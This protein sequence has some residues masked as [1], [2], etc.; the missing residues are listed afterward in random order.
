MTRRIA[1]A[2]TALV[3]AIVFMMALPG[4]ALFRQEEERALRL[5][6]ERDALVLADDASVGDASVWTPQLIE[7]AQSSGARL[8]VVNSQGQVVVDTEGKPAGSAFNR[9]EITSALAGQIVTGVRPSAT[10][11]QQLTYAAVPIRSGGAVVGALRISMPASTVDQSVR[12]L[13]IGLAL[14]LVGIWVLAIVTSW[15]LASWL[16]RPLRFLAEAARAVGA[17]PH[18]RVGRLRGP[19]E[20]AEVAEALDDTAEQ[21]SDALDRSRAVAEESSH[22][23]RTPLAVLRL[24]LEAISDETEG[25][26]HDEA[27]AALAEADRLNH[28]IGQIL[29]LARAGVEAAAVVVDVAE[30]VAAR[31]AV[32]RAGADAQGV[33]LAA[34]GPAHAPLWAS[35]LPGDVD[36]TADELLSNALLYATSSITVDVTSEDEWAV[37]TVRDD[38]PGFPPGE[39]DHV[40]Q[41]FARGSTAR[42]G[43]TGLGLAMV[44]ESARAAGGDAVALPGPGG[45][46]EVRWP[47]TFDDT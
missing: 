20:I 33:T 3:T 17:D 7:Y 12:S 47:R 13:Q 24:R 8:A 39:E 15:G 29:Q 38:G 42:P 22:H 45:G 10:L 5:G 44:R 9:P 21:L 30:V 23:L 36:R 37:L 46:V 2:T 35:A 6:L 11:G 1:L 19:R 34:H 14:A 43:G 16:A 25:P 41:R 32:A 27:E 18:H 31:V 4:L 28:R 26:L 40:F